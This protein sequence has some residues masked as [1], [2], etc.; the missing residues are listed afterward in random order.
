MHGLLV[1]VPVGSTC[2]SV[3]MDKGRYTPPGLGGQ[4][5]GAFMVYLRALVL[6]LWTGGFSMGGCFVCDRRSFLIVVTSCLRCCAADWVVCLRLL[7]SS[8][9][10]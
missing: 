1:G 5:P 4:R 3:V 10:V 7:Y 6:W 2:G 8:I 9:S